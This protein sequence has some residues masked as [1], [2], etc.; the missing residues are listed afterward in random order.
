MD[1]LQALQIRAGYSLA[2]SAWAECI[3]DL[4]AAVPEGGVFYMFRYVGRTDLKKKKTVVRM[5]LR[6]YDRD[7]QHAWIVKTND[8][9]NEKIALTDLVA[10]LADREDYEN[11]NPVEI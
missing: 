1:K 4:K 2:C 6:K 8:T 3:K 9:C 10:V 11:Y 5:K 7:G